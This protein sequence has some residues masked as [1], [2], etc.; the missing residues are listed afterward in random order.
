MILCLF[1]CF[2]ALVIHYLCLL[3]LD[4]FDAAAFLQL[5]SVSDPSK[6]AKLDKVQDIGRRKPRKRWLVSFLLA[7]VVPCIC[8]YWAFVWPLLFV[9]ILCFIIDSVIDSNKYL[10]IRKQFGQPPPE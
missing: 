2:L 5:R 6:R 10:N 9:P 7:V 8:S 4:K 1:V 3:R